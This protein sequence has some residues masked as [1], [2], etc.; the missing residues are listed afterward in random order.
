MLI[1]MRPPL[2]TEPSKWLSIIRWSCFASLLPRELFGIE[3]RMWNT[4]IH[5]INIKIHYPINSYV[6]S[7][8]NSPGLSIIPN[9]QWFLVTNVS[10]ISANRRIQ[11]TYASNMGMTT[12]SYVRRSS[13]LLILSTYRSGLMDNCDQNVVSTSCILRFPQVFCRPQDWKQSLFIC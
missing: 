1:E 8:R 10:I 2:K 9:L 5:W 7:W 4:L 13:L 12:K 11:E 3:S 6:F